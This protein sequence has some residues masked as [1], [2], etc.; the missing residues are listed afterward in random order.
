MTSTNQ[1]LPLPMGRPQ[2]GSAPTT[3][4]AHETC[5][6]YLMRSLVPL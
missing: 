4:P 2:L 6:A 5:P 1:A 3:C